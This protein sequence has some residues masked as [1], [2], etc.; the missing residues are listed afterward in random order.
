MWGAHNEEMLAGNEVIW[1]KIT[2]CYDRDLKNSSRTLLCDLVINFQDQT[3]NAFSWLK[4]CWTG[5]VSRIVSLM[6]YYLQAAM[7]DPLLLARPSFLAWKDD[8]GRD[9]QAGLG[10]TS[11]HQMKCRSSGYQWIAAVPVSR[12]QACSSTAAGDPAFPLIHPC[13]SS[14]GQDSCHRYQ[15]WVFNCW[16]FV[17]S[18]WW[19]SHCS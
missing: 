7:G 16:E 19:V 17:I 2:I 4:V 13:S 5:H 6:S 15:P 11:A 14:H 18:R 3:E 8:C 10:D 9:S 12:R 1:S